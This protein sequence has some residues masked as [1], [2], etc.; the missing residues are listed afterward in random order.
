VRILKNDVDHR[1]KLT[2]TSVS[3]WP[4]SNGDLIRWSSFCSWKLLVVFLFHIFLK[5]ST[6]LKGRTRF[7]ARPCDWCQLQAFC[8]FLFMNNVCCS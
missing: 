1:P 7:Q 6:P 2:S 4:N 5:L 3:N 8:G